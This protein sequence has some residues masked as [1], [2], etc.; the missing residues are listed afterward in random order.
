[1]LKKFTS[2]LPVLSSQ[3]SSDYLSRSG[4][5]DINDSFH[6]NQ[7][8]S[9]LLASAHQ[10]CQLASISLNCS[11]VIDNCRTRKRKSRAG[12]RRTRKDRN[13]HNQ[14][15]IDWANLDKKEFMKLVSSLNIADLFCEVT[16]DTVRFSEGAKKWQMCEY[17][18]QRKDRRIFVG[19]QGFVLFVRRRQHSSS[20]A[21]KVCLHSACRSR[22][23]RYQ[24]K[25][26]L[27]IAAQ[28]ESRFI[29][30]LLV[31]YIT[32]KFFVSVMYKAK[33][34]SLKVIK[35]EIGSFPTGF[36][37]Y[38]SACVLSAVHRLHRIG[39]CHKDIKA[40]NVLI[41]HRGLPQLA[42]FGLAVECKTGRDSYVPNKRVTTM[43]YYP[44]ECLVLGAGTND[45]KIDSWLFGFFVSEI[46]I[47]SSAHMWSKFQNSADPC[48]R[49]HL[50][51]ACQLEEPRDQSL[52]KLL[53]SLLRRD[54]SRRPSIRETTRA[55]YFGDVSFSQLECDYPPDELHVKHLFMEKGDIE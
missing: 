22:T 49:F 53:R 7:Q 50:C 29:S 33:H 21:M 28:R 43:Q 41:D 40:D 26:N 31:Y 19:G 30:D 11:D 9:I 37:K 48:W 27:Q 42:D 38:Y 16:M 54:P 13:N 51:E 52:E 10:V 25:A 32:A 34:S 1:M 12:G 14:L 46:C 3:F 45:Y 35:R 8:E 47:P 2:S 5:A 6:G 18:L 36:V 23:E 39:I 15:C 17:V 24:L 44:P 55:P 4:Q 20:L